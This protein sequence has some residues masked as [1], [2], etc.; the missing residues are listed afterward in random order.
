MPKLSSVSSLRRHSVMF[1]LTTIVF[2]SFGSLYYWHAK[3]VR[4]TYDG[5]TRRIFT[6]APTLKEFLE[7]ERI[8][9]GPDDYIT[10]TL[11]TPILHNTAAKITRVTREDI[12]DVSTGAA[13]VTWQTR[14]RQNL[15]RIHVERGIADVTTEHI[16]IIKHDGI[17]VARARVSLRTAKVPF[18]TLHLLNKEGRPVKDYDLRAAK[19][20]Y[21]RATG[22]YVGEKTVPSNVTYLGYKLRRGLV[23]VDPKVIP[24]R[25]R[26]YVV[27][28]GYA[29]AADTGSAIKGK[30][31]DLAV[32]DKYEE[33]RY[34]RKYVPVFVLETA[35]DW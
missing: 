30:R 22:Y 24:L 15:R 8:E 5:Q 10:P 14:T 17:E 3:S 4:L 33:A 31:I 26:L 11:E 29:Y 27:G 20:H 12:V 18:F 21:M 32:K 28:Y 7:A 19:V 25:S 6:Q 2:L 1:A 35:P 34:N 23:A 16:Q 13:T 9:L